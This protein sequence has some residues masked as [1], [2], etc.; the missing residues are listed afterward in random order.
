MQPITLRNTTLLLICILFT[1]C[2]TLKDRMDM[3]DQAQRGYESAMRW[4]YYGAA[5]AMHRNA[6]GS[7]PTPAPRLNNFKVTSYHVLSRSVADDQNSADQVVEIKYYNVDYMREKTLT[8]QQHWRYD[9]PTHNWHVTS[10]PP[11]FQ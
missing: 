4:G 6:D 11:D 1:A 10:S 8:L 7:V 9:A 5:F 2:A 3:L